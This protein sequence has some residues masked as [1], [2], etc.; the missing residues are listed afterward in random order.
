MPSTNLVEWIDLIY[1]SEL[2]FI[3]DLPYF[4]CLGSVASNIAV[5]RRSFLLRTAIF[6]LRI[7]LNIAA[8]LLF[9]IQHHHPRY[10]DVLHLHLYALCALTASAFLHYVSHVYTKTHLSLLESSL[11]SPQ[12]YLYIAASI[13]VF[14]S[15]FD[16]PCTGIR[17]ARVSHT[18]ILVFGSVSVLVLW[19]TATEIEPFSDA[20]WCYSNP[21]FTYLNMNSGPCP[22]KDHDK[23]HTHGMCSAQSDVGG[24]G[25]D[26]ND[27]PSTTLY[28]SEIHIV[29]Q[30]IAVIAAVYFSGVETSLT[31]YSTLIRKMA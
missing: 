18:I 10:D 9:L 26:C 27:I 23:D 16:R 17:S 21:A 30:C 1:T 20:F 14:N 15:V 25:I 24:T 31:Y 22:T 13:G 19:F 5:D 29:T 6:L 12:R 7:H 3:L 4:L 28:S 11:Q 2:G 8:V